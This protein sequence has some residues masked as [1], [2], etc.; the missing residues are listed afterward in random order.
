MSQSKTLS[1]MSSIGKQEHV[2][3]YKYNM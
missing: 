3:K 1:T 2:L